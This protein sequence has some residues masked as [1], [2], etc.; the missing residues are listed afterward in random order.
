VRIGLLVAKAGSGRRKLSSMER[1]RELMAPAHLLDGVSEDAFRS[2]MHEETIIVE[3]EPDRAKR[4]L[5]GILRTP[6]DRRHAHDLLDGI[7]AHHRLDERQLALVAELRGLLPLARKARPAPRA[8]RRRAPAE[9]KK[10]AAP[11][12]ARRPRRVST[13]G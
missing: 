5:P 3:F 13:T 12:G 10:H 4:A 8:A 7:A 11:R 1:V 9:N 2:L 6:A